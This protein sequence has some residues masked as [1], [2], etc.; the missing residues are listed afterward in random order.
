MAG[1][2]GRLVAPL[3]NDLVASGC[4][5]IRHHR[6]RYTFTL[7]RVQECVT[8]LRAQRRN[9][10]V[11]L[12]V[13]PHFLTG[14]LCERFPDIKINTLGFE[15]PGL[16]ARRKVNEHLEFD[17]NE[18]R[19][20]NRWPTF[21]EHDIIV[22]GEVLEHLYA[23]PTAALAFMRTLLKGHGRLVLTTPNAVA[24]AKRIRMLMGRNPFQMLR[25]GTALGHI[26][27]YTREELSRL[28]E[29]AG[30]G[31]DKV[32]MANYFVSDSRLVNCFHA[33]ASV[34]PSLRCGITIIY[35]RDGR[36][37]PT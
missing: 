2:N 7:D 14:L 9:D 30:L 4:A 28:G 22:M 1:L 20:R 23:A 21:H 6:K 8:A 19:F 31:T 15:G 32:Y 29:M 11:I 24:L 18:T 33:A 3:S 27:E 35:S 36:P 37:P 16:Y 17:L 13:G 25:E 34:I 12:D 26:R 10:A 5:Y